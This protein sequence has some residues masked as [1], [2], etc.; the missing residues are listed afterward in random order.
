M[1]P[2]TKSSSSPFS[3]T[4]VR[5]LSVLLLLDLGACSVV[6]VHEP[7]R[8]NERDKAFGCTTSMAAPTADVVLAALQL[9]GLAYISDSQSDS[10]T[11]DS[12]VG[13]GGA[14][15]GLYIGSAIWG[16]RKVGACRQALREEDPEG[17]A[18]LGDS[19]ED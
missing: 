14:W 9:A 3:P 18:D 6:F 19:T 8:E 12:M 11:K 17:N 1:G 5:L 15:L 13:I 10:S 2:E 4:A 7:P 16:F